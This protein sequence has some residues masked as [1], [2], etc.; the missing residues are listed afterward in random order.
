MCCVCER[1]MGVSAAFM[2]VR[3]TK[4]ALSLPPSP[5]QTAK[6]ILHLHPT[7]HVSLAHTSG[8]KYPLQLTV[9]DHPPHY[10][11]AETSHLM[12]IWLNHLQMQRILVPDKFGEHRHYGNVLCTRALHH[13]LYFL[14]CTHFCS[15]AFSHNYCTVYVALYFY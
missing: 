11:A 15:I 3:I 8:Y 7:F 10:L 14:D 4:I 13:S 5:R 6:A 1:E 12:N 9:A 2:L